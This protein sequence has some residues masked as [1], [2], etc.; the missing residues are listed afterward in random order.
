MFEWDEA[1]ASNNLR[2]HGVP[3]EFAVRVFDDPARVEFDVSRPRDNELRRKCVGRIDDRLFVV[4][5]HK[6]G[7]NRRII[8]ARR[9][10]AN[11][12]KAY[13]HGSHDG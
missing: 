4:V 5:F 1:K 12:D 6:R 11:E 3:F 13:A 7:N 2:K 8:S 10:N 9:T